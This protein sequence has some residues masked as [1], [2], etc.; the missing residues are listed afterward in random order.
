M[1]P[2]YQRARTRV[3]D[4]FAYVVYAILPSTNLQNDSVPQVLRTMFGVH[5]E[6][7]TI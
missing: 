4:V 3:Q 6:N 2:F 7:M 1:Q 5:E